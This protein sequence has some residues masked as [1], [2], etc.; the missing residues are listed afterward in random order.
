[1]LASSIMMATVAARIKPIPPST[2]EIAYRR[3]KRKRE[4]TYE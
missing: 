2:G 4:S 1:M 3:G